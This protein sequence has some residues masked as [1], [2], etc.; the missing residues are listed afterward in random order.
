MGHPE[1]PAGLRAATLFPPIALG[2]DFGFPRPGR[3]G[4][5]KLATGTADSP[6]Y[7]IGP[8]ICRLFAW[9]ARGFARVDPRSAVLYPSLGQCAIALAGGWMPFGAVKRLRLSQ[10]DLR[11]GPILSFGEKNSESITRDLA[12]SEAQVK[13]GG[14]RSWTCG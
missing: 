10:A 2:R 3:H 5:V 4:W 7:R 6:A 8:K 13:I 14:L 12:P 1:L 9:L 11:A